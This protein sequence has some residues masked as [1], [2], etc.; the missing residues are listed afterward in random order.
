[1]AKAFRREIASFVAFFPLFAVEFH[2]KQT[3]YYLAEAAA[4]E[5]SA[6]IGAKVGVKIAP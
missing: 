5:V 4:E 6:A 1:M 3:P 2:K